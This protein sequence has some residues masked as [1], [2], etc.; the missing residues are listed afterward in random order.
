MMTFYRSFFDLSSPP[1]FVPA[2]STEEAVEKIKELAAG[3]TNVK[4][5]ILMIFLNAIGLISIPFLPWIIYILSILLILFSLY[6]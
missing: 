2:K 4:K 1:V 3:S 6:K 5:E